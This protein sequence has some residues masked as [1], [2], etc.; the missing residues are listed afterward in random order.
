MKKIFII[1][2]LFAAILCSCEDALKESPRNF[3]SPTNYY[4]TAADA[5]GAIL[6]VYEVRSNY[7]LLSAMYMIEE[8]HNDYAVPRGSY[9]PIDNIDQ[10][11]ESVTTGRTNGMW[12]DCYIV[13]NRANVVLSRIPGIEMDESTKKKIL[14]EAYFLRAEAYR[15]LV[16]KWGGVPL[17]LE[18]T[19]DLSTLAAPRNSAS[20]VYAQ[21]I[22]DLKIAEVDL[23]EDVG[24][25]TGRASKWAAKIRLADAYLGIEDWANAA[26]KAEEVINSGKYSLVTVEKESDFYK[27][28]ATETC[29]ED[30]FSAHFSDISTAFQNMVQWMHYTDTYGYCPGEGWWC[31]Y[32]NV[33]SPL[34]NNW[35]KNDLRFQFNIYSGFYNKDGD[36]IDNPPAT[37]L[38]FK[39]YIKDANARATHSVPWIRFAEAFLIYAEAACMANN[40]PTDLALERLNIIKRRGYGEALNTPSEID[41]PNGMSAANFRATV[42]KERAYEFMLECRRFWDLKRTNT[43]KQELMDAKGKTFIDTRLLYPIPQPEISNNPALTQADQNPGY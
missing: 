39:K 34:I 31:L 21:I 36:W 20:E 9:A 7:N 43:I 30:I 22:S 16:Q 11:F 6:G 10:P 5:E 26:A 24:V 29:S 25:R 15:E 40:N 2:F 19:V 42:I 12:N 8:S 32:V 14:A 4:K 1:P 13:I 27:I 37:P 18:E 23:P 41:Y 17:R 3:I 38:L 35:D 28:F 33:N